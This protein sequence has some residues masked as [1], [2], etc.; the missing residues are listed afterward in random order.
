MLAQPSATVRARKGDRPFTYCHYLRDENE[1][2]LLAG[3]ATSLF[4]FF[5]LPFYFLHEFVSHSFAVWDDG[6]WR[7]SEA[8]LLRAAHRYFD[9]WLRKENRAQRPFLN[10][11][12]NAHRA[13]CDPKSASDFVKAENCFA[14]LYEYAQTPF[15]TYLLEWATMPAGAPDLAER[16]N[17]L[18][19]LHALVKDPA[20]VTAIFGQ[21]TAA[22]EAFEAARQRLA[23][24]TL[25]RLNR[26]R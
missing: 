23:T 22:A 15:I 6:R 2:Q 4:A 21:S 14:E 3:E 5:D 13:R 17:V 7:F 18:S 16:G 9:E 25:K 20:E 8:Y 11:D 1:V 19:A 26:D 10:M 12:F 24:F